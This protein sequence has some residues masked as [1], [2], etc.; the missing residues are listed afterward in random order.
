MAARGKDEGT[1]VDTPELDRRA[2]AV[3][4]GHSQ[5]IGE[6]LDWLLIEREL[7]IMEWRD[8]LTDTR[9]C[10]G[11]VGVLDVPLCHDGIYYKRPRVDRK[12]GRTCRIC[13]GTGIEEYTLPG[14]YVEVTKSVSDWLNE[15][16]DVDPQEVDRELKALLDR[17]RRL[18][19]ALEPEEI[20]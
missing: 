6:F 2:R 20:E 11:G 17:Q 15:Y 4:E 10:L 7:V 14:Q 5:K 9:K 8:D 18:N 12:K 1:R 3:K 19:A 13:N 16:F